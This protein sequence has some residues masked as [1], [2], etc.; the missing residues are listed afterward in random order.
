MHVHV[1]V[2]HG[3]IVGAYVIIWLY[4]LRL[5]AVKYS[6]STIGKALAFIH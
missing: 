1:S 5:L 6:D 4:L 3:M 2:L